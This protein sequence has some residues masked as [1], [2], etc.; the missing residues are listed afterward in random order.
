MTQDIFDEFGRD[1]ITLFQSWLEQA[2]ANEINDHGAM[3]L[4]T[5]D[6]DGHPHARIV[7][8]KGVNED[9]F[10]FHT[11]SNSQKGADIQ[12]NSLAAL[13]FHWKSLRKQVRVE[14]NVHMIDQAESDE[15]FLTRPPGRQLGAWASDQSSEMIGGR[16]TLTDKIEKTRQRFEREDQIP[17]PP[18]WNGYRVAPFR[19]EFWMDR[20]DRL[21]DRFVYE[22]QDDG[23]WNAMWLYP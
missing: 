6:A 4:A 16:K 14:G 1:P 15:Y 5:S 17:R 13:C 20:E 12:A 18:N 2:E 11:N 3:C 9:G 21:H 23:T 22:L 8:L 19:I 7:L 10:K